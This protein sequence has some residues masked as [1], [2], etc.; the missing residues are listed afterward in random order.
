M[1]VHVTTLEAPDVSVLALSPPRTDSLGKPVLPV[2]P[3]A[4]LQLCLLRYEPLRACS[5]GTRSKFPQTTSFAT[6]LCLFVLNVR[7]CFS[8]LVYFLKNRKSKQYDK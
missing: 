1:N 7:V 2:G 6:H 4:W 5:P 8:F 3:Q